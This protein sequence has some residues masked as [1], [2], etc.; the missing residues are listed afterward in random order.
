MGRPPEAC[1]ESET[2][3]DKAEATTVA[4][5]L[6]KGDRPSP[7]SGNNGDNLHDHARE[8]EAAQPHGPPVFEREQRM[9]GPMLR[10]GH[11]GTSI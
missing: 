10:S 3:R 1:C 8:Q 11:Q 5:G 7:N 2:Q 4:E 9:T 6:Q